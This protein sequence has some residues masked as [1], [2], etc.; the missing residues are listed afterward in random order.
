MIV[1]VSCC[2]LLGYSMGEHVLSPWQQQRVE[3]LAQDVMRCG[4]IPGMSLSVVRGTDSW[5]LPLGVTNITSQEP[6]RT[7]TRFAIGSLSKAFTSTLLVSL[8]MQSP[9]NWTLNTPLAAILEKSDLFGDEVRSREA[10]V[11]DILSHRLGLARADL[12]LFSGYPDAFSLADMVSGLPCLPEHKPFRGGYVYSNVLYS[13]AGYVVER[14]TNQSFAQALK[15]GLLDPL[16]MASTAPYGSRSTEYRGT[17]ESRPENEQESQAVPYVVVK[18]QLQPADPSLFS[19]LEPFLPALGLASN[20]PDMIRWLQLQLGRADPSSPGQTVIPR[21]VIAATH[22]PVTPHIVNNLKPRFPQPDLTFAYGLGWEQAVYKGFRRAWHSGSLF[23][24]AS[25]IWLFPDLDLGLFVAVNGPAKS[26]HTQ[27]RLT[28]LLYYVSDLLLGDRPWLDEKSVCSYP[29]PPSNIPT[30]ETQASLVRNTQHQEGS[31]SNEALLNTQRSTDNPAS[32][33]T[34]TILEQPLSPTNRVIQGSGPA[35][36]S[37]TSLS[38]LLSSSVA[39][40]VSGA[41]GDL[42]NEHDSLNPASV[43]PCPQDARVQTTDLLRYTGEYFNKL[44]GKVS[45]SLLNTQ[46]WN[47]PEQD[48]VNSTIGEQSASPNG[49]NFEDSRPI[50]QLPCW[51]KRKIG[52]WLNPDS[53]LRILFGVK[54]SGILVYSENRQSL[55]DLPRTSVHT[56]EMVP[57]GIFE[58]STNS[59]NQENIT[60]PVLFSDF[61]SSGIPHLLKAVWQEEEVLEFGRGSSKQHCTPRRFSQGTYSGALRLYAV[62][63]EMFPLSLL[64]L[65]FLSIINVY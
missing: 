6:V 16:G 50:Q 32:S 14:L 56:F 65:L 49:D 8:L 63:Q 9:N 4:R 48:K 46:A 23:G 59:G 22:E 10:N 60:M 53:N 13:L 36:T 64:L 47:I 30:S 40:K 17:R 28:A 35:D 21:S 62:P 44:F 1:A 15:A 5:T 19:N 42:L 55:Q 52:S 31:L 54:F 34:S 39:A 38:S 2:C 27:N 24:F 29:A 45:V 11:K 26:P 61:D 7:V 3:R 58:F 51:P 37:S 43:I 12:A 33:S 41:G 57:T 20:G 25:Q 18:D